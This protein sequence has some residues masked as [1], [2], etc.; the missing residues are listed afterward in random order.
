MKPS[1][2]KK[3]LLGKRIYVTSW[4]MGVKEKLRG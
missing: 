4:V 1:F 3:N 2:P